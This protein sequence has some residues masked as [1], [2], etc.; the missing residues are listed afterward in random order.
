M[1]TVIKT[2]FHGRQAVNLGTSAYIMCWHCK[3][4]YRATFPENCFLFRSVICHNLSGI[5]KRG[6]VIF[7]VALNI[8]RF[9]DLKWKLFLP[10]YSGRYDTSSKQVDKSNSDNYFRHYWGFL[11]SRIKAWTLGD[12]TWTVISFV[13]AEC[14]KLFT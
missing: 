6:S 4:N 14:P 7:I 11:Q 9:I 1:Y 13:N 2:S 8:N 5:W 12:I 10:V 3:L